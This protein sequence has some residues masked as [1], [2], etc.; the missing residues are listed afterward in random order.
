MRAH[1]AI[2]L[3]LLLPAVAHAGGETL[4]M[5]AR[6]GERWA[7]ADR[8]VATLVLGLVGEDA[9]GGEALA[10]R[11][12][13]LVSRPAGADSAP[14]GLRQ[15]VLEGR[16]LFIEGQYAQAL[17]IL[18]QAR[19]AFHANPSMVATD[20]GLRDSLYKALVY[21]AHVQLRQG[22]AAQARRAVT[23]LLRGFPDRPISTARYGPELVALYKEVHRSM[24]RLP[25]GRL[26]I[27]S[28]PSGSMVFLDERYVGVAPITVKSLYPGS[29]RV[30]LQRADQRG[31]V[32]T[33]RLFGKDRELTLD[34]RL[35]RV[36]DTRGRVSLVYADQASRKQQQVRHTITL[37]Q[38]MGAARV[39]LLEQEILEGHKALGATLVDARRGTTLRSARVSLVPPDQAPARVARLAQFISTGRRGADLEI[40]GPVQLASRPALSTGGGIYSWLKWLTLGVAVAGVAAG[41]TL[42]VLDGR[43]TCDTPDGMLCPEYMDTLAGGAALTAAGGAAAAAAGALFY[44]DSRDQASGEEARS[45]SVAPNGLGL[46]ARLTW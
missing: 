7:D 25:R 17:T 23:A 21:L 27:S 26:I 15:K 24:S 20:Q 46:S 11:L 38:R 40:Q 32:H 31:R 44:L 36:L 33:V 8:H 3:G 18:E 2:L 1:L 4:V 30:Y 22:K 5:E 28:Q 13:R 39:I 37:A 42:L 6:V 43:K 10:R 19:R 29:Y 34:M 16:R 12:E 9:L 35:D 45:V 41:A 14:D